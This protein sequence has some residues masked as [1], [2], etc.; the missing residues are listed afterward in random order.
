MEFKDIKIGQHLW[1]LSSNEL[2]MVAKFDEG[3]YEVCGPWEGGIDPS[4]CQIIG[5][6]EFPVKH[7]ETKL[8]YGS[9]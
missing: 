5:L 6:V 3:G 2:L 7:K 1:V 4:H 8:Y 9:D